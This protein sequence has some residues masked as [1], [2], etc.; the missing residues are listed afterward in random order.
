MVSRAVPEGL[1]GKTSLLC[2]VWT[3]MSLYWGRI[4][5]TLQGLQTS[6]PGA[7]LMTKPLGPPIS[8]LFTTAMARRCFDRGLSHTSKLSTWRANQILDAWS[9]LPVHRHHPPSQWGSL[10]FPVDPGWWQ[11]RVCSAA[12]SLSAD[13][14]FEDRLTWA[15]GLPWWPIT[16]SETPAGRDSGQSFQSPAGEEHC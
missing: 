15:A 6:Q 10:A 7:A 3:P 13:K 11:W 5:V 9:K 2:A 8:C 16:P 12:A 4:C 1:T 14:C